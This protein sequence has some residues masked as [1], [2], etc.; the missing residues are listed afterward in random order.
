MV[1]VD[2]LEGSAAER[3]SLRPGD[4]IVEVA[5]EEVSSPPEVAAKV[6]QAQ[7][8]A[9]K[10]VLLL[11]D[12]SGDLR[13]VA[14][15]FARGLRGR[16]CGAPGSSPARGE[17]ARC[18]LGKHEIALRYALQEQERAQIAMLDGHRRLARDRRV[19]M[20]VGERRGRRRAASA[21]HWR[22]H[23]PPASARPGC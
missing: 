12:R 21:D 9:K 8:D 19:G 11:I 3:E 16:G 4:V 6:G 13:F 18:S 22:H 5:Q 14:L 17:G 7:Q 23:R 10:S 20:R 15:R 2:V 1:I